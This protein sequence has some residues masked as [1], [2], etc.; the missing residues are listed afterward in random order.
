MQIA[1][2]ALAD[3]DVLNPLP[4]KMDVYQNR[5]WLYARRSRQVS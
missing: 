2:P 1:M 5:H 4:T 3:A